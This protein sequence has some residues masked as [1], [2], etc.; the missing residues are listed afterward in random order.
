MRCRKASFL[1]AAFSVFSSVFSREGVLPADKSHEPARGKP[2]PALSARDFRSGAEFSL[3]DSGGKVLLAQ[4]MSMDGCPI[5]E[6]QAGETRAT[7]ERCGREDLQSSLFINR[8]Q[9]PDDAAVGKWL[10][11]KRLDPDRAAYLTGKNYFPVA[12]L[13]KDAPVERSP[14]SQ[15]GWSTIAEPLVTCVADRQGKIVML[16]WGE[17][18]AGVIELAIAAASGTP[19]CEAVAPLV[20]GLGARTIEE[21]EAAYRTLLAAGVPFMREVLSVLPRDAANPDAREACRRLRDRIP[22]ARSRYEVM[23]VVG[24]ES[25]DEGFQKAADALFTHPSPEAFDAF[26]N[27]IPSPRRSAWPRALAAF[28][29]A[30][31]PRLR[32]EALRVASGDRACPLEGR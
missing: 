14:G 32:R 30:P 27:G 13:D 31:D 1:F 26:R 12:L 24:D 17:L 7:L 3:A 23:S 15:N 28:Q 21:R 6:R 4:W 9:G 22:L 16:C 20:S 2:L 29:D 10:S 19:F 25:E 11:E 8:W 18:P 5:C